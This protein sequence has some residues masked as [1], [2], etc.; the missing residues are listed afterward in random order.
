MT[1]GDSNYTFSDMHLFRAASLNGFDEMV[2]GLGLDSKTL[3][4]LAGL[5]AKALLPE[6]A[7]QYLPI[8]GLERLYALTEQESQNFDLAARLGSQQ[9]MSTLLGVLGFVMQQCK[10]VGEALNELKHYFSFQ[11]QGAYL[12]LDVEQDQVAFTFIFQDSFR[13]PSTRY[14]LEFALAAAVSILKSLCGDQWK[15]LFV[16]FIH[17]EPKQ[18]SKLKKYFYSPVYF[19]Q[20]RSAVIFSASDLDIP[21][22]S[23]NPQLNKILH[24]YLAQL[25]EQ[26]SNDPTAQIE[27]LI[28]QALTSGSCS[29]DKVAAFMG[30]HRR[31]LHRVLKKSGTSYTQLLEKVR[32][33]LALKMLK[34]SNV[35]ITLI[36]DMLCYSEM[37][38]FSRAFKKWTGKTPKEYRV[39]V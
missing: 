17:A 15:P 30:V 37:S 31:T 26:F 13:L 22:T 4:Q 10:T 32:Q 12:K 9:E 28:Q 36:A 29:A 34:Q 3:L 24:A 16:Q 18:S 2:T 1:L 35:S 23:A 8:A 20:E 21:I 5:P 27:K 33:D 38:A 39:Q 11:V 14:T 6:S 19:N 7:D 25:E